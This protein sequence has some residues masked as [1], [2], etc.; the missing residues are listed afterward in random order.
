MNNEN[1]SFKIKYPI[2]FGFISFLTYFFSNIIIVILYLIVFNIKNYDKLKISDNLNLIF[3]IA[4][5]LILFLYVCLTGCIKIYKIKSL[6]E[7]FKNTY[8]ISIIYLILLL[9]VIVDLIYEKTSFKKGLETLPGFIKIF[10]IAFVEETIFR[11]IFCRFLALKYGKNKKGIFLTVLLSS[12]FFGLAHTLNLLSGIPLNAIIQQSV[13]AFAVGCFF[14]G[15]YLKSGNLWETILIHFLIDFVSLFSV[16]F[17]NSN[18]TFKTAVSA[19]GDTNII[20]SFNRFVIILLL[21]YVIYLR[22]NKIENL[23]SN[24]ELM[25][26]YELKK[27]VKT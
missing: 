6:K 5:I 2:T 23:I 14:A 20:Y 7:M 21:T 25:K 1:L 11:G 19:M 16:H 24:V 12:A 27:H 9:L 22:K 8:I 18:Q 13:F 15:M 10:Q 26:K 3:S 17:T 4:S